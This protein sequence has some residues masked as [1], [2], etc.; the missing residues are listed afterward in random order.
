[1]QLCSGQDSATS[2]QICSGKRSCHCKSLYYVRGTRVAL[3]LRW[4][5]N[6]LK[7]CG[8]MCVGCS[9]RWRPMIGTSWRSGWAADSLLT[10]NFCHVKR[11]L[12]WKG[13]K[14]CTASNCQGVSPL[15]VDLERVVPIVVGESC[16]TGVSWHWVQHQG[17]SGFMQT[18]RWKSDFQVLEM[19][20]IM[21][22]FFAFSILEPHHDKPLNMWYWYMFVF[23]RWRFQNIIH[24]ADDIHVVISLQLE[25]PRLQ[26]SSAECLASCPWSGWCLPRWVWHQGN[27]Y[28]WCANLL[29]GHFQQICQGSASYGATVALLH[30]YETPL[31]LW[32]QCISVFFKRWFGFVAEFTSQ[33]STFLSSLACYETEELIE[34]N[35]IKHKHWNAGMFRRIFATNCDETPGI[36]SL[37]M[38]ASL[39]L[40]TGIVYKVPCAPTTT[41]HSGAELDQADENCNPSIEKT[42][43]HPPLKLWKSKIMLDNFKLDI[44]YYVILCDHV[45]SK[46]SQFP[47]E[48]FLGLSSNAPTAPALVGS[49]FN[50]R[51]TGIFWDLSMSCWTFWPDARSSIA[52][53]ERWCRSVGKGLGGHVAMLRLQKMWQV[54][55][56]DFL[57]IFLAECQWQT[58]WPWRTA[59][60]YHSWTPPWC[61]SPLQSTTPMWGT[62]M[63][64]WGSA[65][66]CAHS[67]TVHGSIQYT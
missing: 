50:P 60:V 25:G 32:T 22:P 40:I 3:G 5:C 46:G 15:Y 59:S 49:A 53:M 35:W 21:S 31:L 6:V 39:D 11:A 23:N 38:P 8:G 19:L 33:S 27:P 57:H 63:G 56:F 26:R 13:T 45:K 18:K 16:T 54:R 30:P 48:C 34:I 61:I 7:A 20:Q 14:Q 58:I 9:C 24:L 67:H 44:W 64:T 47:T 36:A 65:R 62:Y 29:R 28:Q 66:K 10:W 41:W 42:M 55:F 37:L 4:G 51:R 12:H 52:R 1:M 2:N 43:K 17:A